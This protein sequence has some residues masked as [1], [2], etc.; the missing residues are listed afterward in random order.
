MKKKFLTL[1]FSIFAFI[2]CLLFAGCTTSQDPSNSDNTTPA[3]TIDVMFSEDGKTL[4]RF[5]P[6]ND[7]T[8]YTVPEGVKYIADSA[9]AN[10]ENLTKVIFPSTLITVGNNAF[11]KCFNLSTAEI[12]SDI[13][14]GSHA[15]Y[16]CNLLNIDTSK[17][18]LY[19]ERSFYY[20]GRLN[21]ITI[22]KEVNTLPKEVF[23][24]F[25]AQTVIFE[26][27]TNLKFIKE[28][29]FCF[30]TI[31]SINIPSSCEFIG[32]KAFA[33]TALTSVYIGKNITTIQG[34]AFTSCENLTTVEFETGRS[35]RLNFLESN[36]KGIFSHCTNLTTVTNYPYENINENC[37]SFCSNLNSFT[38]DT[39]SN[40]KYLEISSYA[41]KSCH[42]LKS[43]TITPYTNVLA[44]AFDSC[45]NLNTLILLNNFESNENAFSDCYNL[46]EIY[47]FSNTV[48]TIGEGIAEYA[49][50]IYTSPSSQSKI[51]TINNVIYYDNGTDFI[52][53]GI[54]NRNV[55]SIEFDTNTTEINKYAF[56]ECN[57][58]TSVI[59]HENVK[60]INFN[61]FSGVYINI[62]TVTINSADIAN[63][64]TQRSS[65]G[66]LLYDATTVYIQTGLSV[67]NSTY[68]L[69]NFTKQTSSDKF[70][71]DKYVRNA[72]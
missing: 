42:S 27:T 66:K 39:L 29:A 67:A 9:F 34:E 7:E 51:K 44:F 2:P 33:Y 13:S 16:Y 15:F 35:D 37:F 40:S 47:N 57:M 63:T 25:I 32:E 45:Y 5:S 68:L 71:H 43:F 8:E 19:G 18:M 59:L 24:G 48:L 10:C 50:D 6:D 23:S 11:Y 72:Q 12:N 41:F 56:Y 26:E 64:F 55:T 60:N 22:A 36:C 21:N 31:S 65:N 54:G 28:K 14:V 3:N 70:G 53:I 4:H 30:S 46:F 58:L 38:F 61:A 49:K 52:A 62:S 17:I 1:I 20:G 69:E